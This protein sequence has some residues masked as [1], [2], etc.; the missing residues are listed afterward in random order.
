MASTATRISAPVETRDRRLAAA[1]ISKCLTGWRLFAVVTVAYLLYALVVT[2]PLAT[3]VS[4]LLSAPNYLEDAAGTASSL[5][6]M[7]QHHIVP[8]VPAHMPDLNAPGGAT[9]PWALYLSQA[10]AILP[11]WL[12]S[13]AF[14]AVAGGNVFMLLGFVASGLSMFAFVL[15][16]FDS[17]LVALFAGFVFAFYPFPVAAASVHYEF[18]HGWPIVLC[19]WGLIELANQPNRRHALLAGAATALAMWFNPYYELIAG[20]ALGTCLLICVAVGHARGDTR[21][22]LTASATALLPV[23]AL[24]MFFALLLR[25][26]GAS[27]GTVPRPFFQVYAFSAH[28]W[29]YLLPGPNSLLVGHITRPYLAARLG[30]ANFS[31]TAVY[32]GYTVIVFAVAGF[33]PAVRALRAN[34]EALA[35]RRVIAVLTAGVLAAVAFISSGPPTVS[36]L[37]ISVPLPSDLIYHIT[38]S[39]QT[40]TRFVILLELALVVMMAAALTQMRRTLTG[41]RLVLAFGLAGLLLAVDLWASPAQRTV[42]ATP[43]PAY[44]WL[45]HH[46]G[47]IV[48]DYPILPAS[49]PSTAQALYWGAY[50]EHPLFEG[51]G[52]MTTSES[53]KLDLADLGGPQ[54][55]GKLA[56]YGVRYIVVH[57][58]SPGSSAPELRAHGYRPVVIDRHGPSLWQVAAAP[59]ST[60]VDAKSGFSWYAGYPSYDTRLLQGRGVLALHARDCGGCSGTVSF[61]ISGFGRDVRLTVRYLR[62]GAILGRFVAPRDHR[63]RVSVPNV[64]LA[65]GHSQLE[66]EL[67]HAGTAEVGM[68]TARLTL[69]H[70]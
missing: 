9:Q 13:I 36:L 69:R 10:V 45:R 60:T 32:P 35:D 50:D 59:A 55:A 14:G 53:L 22:A 34:R 41:R 63:V 3:N 42:S 30:I 2:W 26:G 51:Y 21:Q 29:D 19:A 44:A 68:S 16:L 57:R 49:N 46:P 24:G 67:S 38:P 66:L 15:R 70:T 37:G 18:V 65:D 5:G 25:L 11:W 39:W 27:V 43:K 12:L 20:F 40:F 17:R 28:L 4:G 54:T 62:T 31:D 61:F 1:A 7:V 58:G 23:A 56:G 48:A 33:L 52:I 6:Y 64:K 8:F 47:G